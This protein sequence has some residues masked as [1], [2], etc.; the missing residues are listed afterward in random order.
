MSALLP[1]ARCLARGP[2]TAQEEAQLADF[3]PHFKAVVQHLP[4]L[5]QVLQLRPAP[6]VHQSSSSTPQPTV[7]SHR[8]W[9]CGILHMLLLH[10]NAVI[11]RAVAEAGLLPVVLAMAFH[12][13][14]CSA[15]Q[16]RAVEMLRSSL[17]SSVLQ[18]WQGLFT[19][20]YGQQLQQPGSGE[21]L[22]PLHEALAQ[23]GECLSDCGG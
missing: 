8:V 12:H 2:H 1:A 7:G 11:D 22:P 6:K 23:I 16:C 14:H 20:G 10:N 9:A 15:V 4:Q 17:R 13:G 18:L 21:L 3:Q 19:A 5:Q